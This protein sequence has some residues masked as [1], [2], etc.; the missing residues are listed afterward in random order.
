MSETTERD[1]GQD[2]DMPLPCPVCDLWK[3]CEGEF[4]NPDIDPMRETRH[5]P[6]CLL[7]REEGS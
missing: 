7:G 5:H 6:A 4:S 2:R 3:L 1:T